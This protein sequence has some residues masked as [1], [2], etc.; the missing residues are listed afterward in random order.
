MG[1]AV[2]SFY[3]LVAFPVVEAPRWKK[4]YIVN[5]FFIL[6]SWTL[7][8]IGYLVHGRWE[9]RQKRAAEA[10]LDEDNLKAEM[11]TDVKHMA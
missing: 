10:A 5:F 4:G 6:G 2:N 3:P 11:S 9:R 8:T 1:F 7:L